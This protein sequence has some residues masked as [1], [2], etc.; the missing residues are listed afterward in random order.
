V[1]WFGICWSACVGQSL[2]SRFELFPPCPVH[3]LK[4]P[5]P[6]QALG[7][8]KALPDL[9]GGV[10]APRYICCCTMTWLSKSNMIMMMMMQGLNET[11]IIFLLQTFTTAVRWFHCPSQVKKLADGVYD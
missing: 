11:C 10:L 5:H 3:V 2:S 8:C 4:Q 7:S 1:V 9:P 6:A